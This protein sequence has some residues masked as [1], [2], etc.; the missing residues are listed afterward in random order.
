M[1]F[2]RSPEESLPQAPTQRRRRRRRM[3]AE[4]AQRQSERRVQER[5]RQKIALGIGAA[6]VLVVVAI[7]SIGY[8][9]EFYKPPRELAGQVRD[10]RFTMGDLVDRIRVLQGVNR[11]QGGRVDLS[12][13]PFE[14]LQN[15]IQAE[16]IRQAAP[17][18]GFS[19]T[20]ENIDQELRRRFRPIPPPGQQVDEGQLD[21]EYANGLTTF[22]TSTKL[23]EDDYRRL[24]EEELL[25]SQLSLL[26]DAG[27]PDEMEQVEVAWIRMDQDG[28]ADPQEVR[29]RLQR[30]SF[31]QV[32]AEVNVPDGFTNP[33]GYVGWVPEGAFPELDD[34]L[35]GNP[36]REL[37]PLPAGETSEPIFT[38]EG[39]YIIHIITG[40]EVQ[41]LR[42]FQALADMGEGEFES[43]T[44][45]E[46]E[47]IRQELRI[48]G[49]LAQQ[50][51]D[52]WFEDQISRGSDEEWLKI[53]FDSE[54]YGW[55]ADQVQLSAPRVSGGPPVGGPGVP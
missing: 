29:N 38:Q 4:D 50:E 23:S 5:R 16:I 2:P 25:R 14:Y 45:E 55:V 19:V 33:E 22:L 24:V 47:A 52:Q 9:V 54:L 26:I 6:L 37:E 11:Y 39:V 48:R 12:T 46:R 34:E 53:R 18:L 35:Y 28:A 1:V 32:A 49:K 20:D 27:I 15:M 51:V 21:Q 44:Q 31:A 13:V 8:Y 30:E 17:G 10:V 43:L 41:P 36:A 42:G 3:S 7:V 40:P